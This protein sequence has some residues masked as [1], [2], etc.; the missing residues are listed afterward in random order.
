MSMLML[1]EDQ[2]FTLTGYVESPG[3][4]SIVLKGYLVSRRPDGIYIAPLI[5][6]LFYGASGEQLRT[7]RQWL[8]SAG[9]QVLLSRVAGM[10]EVPREELWWRKVAE[11]AVREEPAAREV[12]PTQVVDWYPI[13]GASAVLVA[14]LMLWLS[15]R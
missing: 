8:P 12:I 15:R 9:E 4:Q 11:P 10:P 7:W 13:V 14:L 2:S 6:Q 3:Y 5:P 1:D